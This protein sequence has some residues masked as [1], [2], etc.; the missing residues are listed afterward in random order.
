MPRRLTILA[1]VLTVLAGAPGTEPALGAGK[2][3]LPP[4][5]S[6]MP[7][8]WLPL[9]EHGWTVVEPAADSRLIYVSSSEGDDESGRVYSPGDDAVGQDPT[10]PSGRVMPFRSVRAAMEKA[11]YSM[12]DWVL[13]KRG[14]TWRDVR[15]Q[16]RGGRSQ[17]EPAVIC[18]Y[19]TASSRPVIRGR[20]GRVSL[21]SPKDGVQNAV[22]KDLELYCSFL[23]PSASDYGV[24]TAEEVTR[25]MGRMRIRAFSGSRKPTV[26]VLVENCRIRFGAFDVRGWNDRMTNVVL[27]RNVVL[28]KYPPA[29]HTMGMWGAYASVLLEEC[30]FDH[31]G[32]LLQ[33][34]P[35]NEGKP[36]R[37]NPLSHNTYCTG[38]FST[39]FRNNTFLRAASIGNKFTANYGPGSVR[40][41]VVDNNLYVDGEIGVS[42]GG[43]K[44][45]PL[46]WVDCR[47]SNN[48]MLDVGRSR[49]T[50]RRLAWYVG[51]R[52]W[53]GGAITRNL[54]LHQPRE[55]IR[56]VRGILLSA[57]QGDEDNPVS[58]RDVL[59]RG[60]VFH[61]LR[62]ARAAIMIGGPRRMRGVSITENLFQ[63]P[64]LPSS[65]I[66]TGALAD[67]LSFHRNVYH[68]GA[69]PEQ[70]FRVGDRSLSFDQWVR[71]S[72]E[73]GARHEE[74]SFPDSGRCIE[75]YMQSLGM[76]PS[77]DAFIAAAREQSRRNWKPEFTAQAVND[78][79]RAGFG[80]GDSP[81]TAG[82]SP[83]MP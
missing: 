23:D 38:M 6:P 68:S 69:E 43:N 67:G 21:G 36:G 15:I 25:Q 82:P 57:G 64:G 52:D 37:A 8:R 20:H 32:W 63:F 83:Q 26:N 70:W 5:E 73:Q 12:P 24:D 3:R 29:G 49:P 9:D 39:I 54:F 1:V 40:D 10:Q 81:Q 75:T 61:G 41:L 42:M 17:S 44:L 58:M 46:R 27:R 71:E 50:G 65:L 18:A 19:G 59:V 76:E 4:A 7:E 13:L 45:A 16:A 2:L 22:V 11:R 72:G 62:N 47:I 53:D 79:I 77:I 30:I 35:E 51:A 48:V 14:D 78:W 80:M 28:D 74:V 33:R 31:N 66:V 56:N 34:V 55:E 60:N